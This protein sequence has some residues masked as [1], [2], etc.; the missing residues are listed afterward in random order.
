ML[1]DDDSE[2]KISEFDVF[3]EANDMEEGYRS[4]HDDDS[5]D[6]NAR[7]EGSDEDSS[8]DSNEQGMDYS[9]TVNAVQ[10]RPTSSHRIWT[11]WI[12]SWSWTW[13]FQKLSERYATGLV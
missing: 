1:S 5:G 10:T 4:M 9:I 3:D 12:Q 6:D 8:D 13:S 11:I 7:S 2:S